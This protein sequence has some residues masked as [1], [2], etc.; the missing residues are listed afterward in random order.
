[1]TSVVYRTVPPNN[2]SVLRVSVREWLIFTFVT[3]LNDFRSDKPGLIY[4]KP[5]QIPNLENSSYEALPFGRFFRIKH[6]CWMNP[7]GMIF[8][9]APR[10]EKRTVQVKDGIIIL[11]I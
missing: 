10:N 1:M 7:Q 8:P 3:V 4:R 6:R 11:D 9:N 2:P 5:D